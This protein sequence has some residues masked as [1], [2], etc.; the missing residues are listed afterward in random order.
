[1]HT[2]SSMSALFSEPY[3]ALTYTEHKH[4]KGLYLPFRLQ[5][6]RQRRS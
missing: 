4:T 5:E 3:E 6:Q 2:S 1:M